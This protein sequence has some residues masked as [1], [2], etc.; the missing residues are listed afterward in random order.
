MYGVVAEVVVVESKFL[1]GYPQWKPSGSLPLKVVL[2]SLTE[3]LLNAYK[4]PPLYP[5]EAED[6]GA[7]FEVNW[8][9]VIVS[10]PPE[11]NIAPPPPA[12]AALF[13]VNWAFVIVSV[14]PL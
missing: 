1:P 12:G 3:A 10:V 7:L 11:A 8:A 13:E 4:A 5:K 14:P 9:F 6:L 2:R